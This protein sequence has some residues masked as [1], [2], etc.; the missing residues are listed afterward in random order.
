[1]LIEFEVN[2]LSTPASDRPDPSTLSALEKRAIENADAWST[3]GSAYAMEH[4]TRPSTIGFVLS[5]NPLA[6][7]AWIGEKFLEW[8]DEDPV[9]DDILTNVSLYW[10]TGGF[11]RSIYPYR[12]LFGNPFPSMPIPIFTPWYIHPPTY[13]FTNTHYRPRPP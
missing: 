5:S 12:Q 2:M 9:I 4:A 1:M 8:S 7:L 10:F 11:P 6:L 13:D 3:R